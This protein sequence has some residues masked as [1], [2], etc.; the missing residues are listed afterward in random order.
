MSLDLATKIVLKSCT[1]FVV[2]KGEAHV[3]VINA[4]DF[5]IFPRTFQTRDHDLIIRV[6]KEGNGLSALS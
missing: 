1:L 6:N 5:F 2:S 3:Q 4:W